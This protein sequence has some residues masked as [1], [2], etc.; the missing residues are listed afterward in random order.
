MK[1][2]DESIE[3][4]AVFNYSKV[5]L[6]NETNLF[7]VLLLKILKRNFFSHFFIPQNELENLKI[8]V[9]GCLDVY[10]NHIVVVVINIYDSKDNKQK[11]KKQ[12]KI[13]KSEESHEENSVQVL[14]QCLEILVTC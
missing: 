13:R 1:V 7:D 11:Q 6:L 5:V 3:D 10:L 14:Y 8:T 9:T 4:G 12:K 2:S